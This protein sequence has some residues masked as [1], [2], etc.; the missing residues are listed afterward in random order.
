MLII[1]S[2]PAIHLSIIWNIQSCST[3]LLV[4]QQFCSSP[5][6]SFLRYKTLTWCG[7]SF[8]EHV[9]LQPR[10][11]LKA[12]HKIDTVEKGSPTPFIHRVN[13]HCNCTIRQSLLGNSMGCSTLCLP[14]HILQILR[15]INFYRTYHRYTST[16][17]R[18]YYAFLLFIFLRERVLIN[19]DPHVR[20]F[21]YPH[22]QD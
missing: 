7:A 11:K 8:L 17:W 2:F 14:D 21:N 5:C 3:V 16:S 9:N 20:S 1:F 19:H 10:Q 6:T 18:K 13:I 12:I 15:E 4:P 22:H